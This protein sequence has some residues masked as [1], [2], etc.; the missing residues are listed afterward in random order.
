MQMSLSTNI[1]LGVSEFGCALRGLFGSLFHN[2]HLHSLSTGSSNFIEVKHVSDANIIKL[3]GFLYSFLAHKVSFLS[4][5]KS[6]YCNTKRK[7]VSI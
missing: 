7:L 1:F 5:Y 3:E 6:H 2:R 4:S